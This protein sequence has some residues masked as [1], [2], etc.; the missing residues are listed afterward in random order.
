MNKVVITGNLCDAPEAYTTQ[1]GV[2]RATFRV[3]VTRPFK[4]DETDF[5]TVVAWRQAAD[6][7]IKYLKKGNKVAVS[8]SIQTRSYD[9][10]DG[11]KRYVTEIIA[12]TVEGLTRPANGTQDA[13]AKADEDVHETFTETEDGDSP[14]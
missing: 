4:R 5:L 7:C 11:S 2:S 3:A 9:A 10:K 13:P 6:Y 14:F 1:S 12:D 8:G